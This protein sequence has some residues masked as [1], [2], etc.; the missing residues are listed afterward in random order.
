MATEHLTD[1][2]KA[3]AEASL[4]LGKIAAAEGAQPGHVA[5]LSKTT[6][7]A[8]AEWAQLA[9]DMAIVFALES[10]SA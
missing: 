7:S 9:L 6:M 4:A 3:A 10:Q 8:I 1:L 5:Y 2:V